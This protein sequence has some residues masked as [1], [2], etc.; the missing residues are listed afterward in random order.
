MISYW[1][2]LNS[3]ALISFGIWESRF[4]SIQPSK[5][6][7]KLLQKTEDSFQYPTPEKQNKTIYH[8]VLDINQENCLITIK[9]EIEHSSQLNKA[10]K[11][12]EINTCPIKPGLYVFLSKKKVYTTL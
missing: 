7:Q 2:I 10:L 4:W 8:F 3:I 6:T 5:E 1:S 12:T 11:T 9:G